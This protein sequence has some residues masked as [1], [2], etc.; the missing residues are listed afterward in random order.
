M[1]LE[2]ILS[3]GLPLIVISVITLSRVLQKKKGN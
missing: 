1:N 2:E 3:I